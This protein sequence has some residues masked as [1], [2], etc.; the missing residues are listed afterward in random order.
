MKIVRDGKPAVPYLGWDDLIPGHTYMEVPHTGPED[1]IFLFTTDDKLVDVD[2][3][4]SYEGM[5][6][7]GEFV[8]VTT[9]I[10]VMRE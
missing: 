3:G 4:E 2:D 8:E 9:H 1:L 10:V 5:D 7:T 6:F